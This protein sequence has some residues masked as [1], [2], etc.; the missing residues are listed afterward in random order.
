MSSGSISLLGGSGTTK[1]IVS[2]WL[3]LKLHLTGRPLTLTWPLLIASWM[4]RRLRLRNRPCRYLSILRS[5]M[6]TP[7]W[8][9][10]R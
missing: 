3:S 2:P 6:E 5:L 7:T 1:S 10:S 8:S 9:S 4:K